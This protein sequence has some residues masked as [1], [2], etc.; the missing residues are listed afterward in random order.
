M[1]TDLDS[2]GYLAERRHAPGSGL[3]ADH[4]L[5]THAC[6]FGAFAH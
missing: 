4:V 5:G 6:G 2:S 1:A 3:L